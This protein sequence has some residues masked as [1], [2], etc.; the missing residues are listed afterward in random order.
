MANSTAMPGMLASKC[1]PLMLGTIT[2]HVLFNVLQTLHVPYHVLLVAIDDDMC[3][4]T[5]G[6]QVL[7]AICNHKALS[8]IR[9]ATHMGQFENEHIAIDKQ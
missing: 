1:T 8:T 9:V 3:I 2:P 7:D 6:V 4:S 5:I